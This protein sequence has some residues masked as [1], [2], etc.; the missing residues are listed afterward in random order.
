MSKEHTSAAKHT[1][2]PMAGDYEAQT[3]AVREALSDFSY[4]TAN[5]TLEESKFELQQALAAVWQAALRHAARPK[6]PRF[7]MTYC[8]QCGSEQG[9]GDEGVSHCS[10]H[11]AKATGSAA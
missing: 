4:R 3:A 10:D 8:S 2:G 9:P 7:P 11:R 1:P 5:K 6:A